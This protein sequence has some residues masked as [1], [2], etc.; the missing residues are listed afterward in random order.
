MVSGAFPRRTEAHAIVLLKG[1]KEPK[2]HADTRARGSS[3]LARALP[4]MSE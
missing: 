4:I 3:P 2:L 1:A